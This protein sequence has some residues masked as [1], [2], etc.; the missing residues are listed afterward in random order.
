MELTAHKAWASSAS[1]LAMA[2]LGKFTGLVAVPPVESV[3]DALLQLGGALVAA[4][5]TWAA[6][7][8]AEN[9]P[10]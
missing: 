4:G 9:K 6:T 2:L 3:T 5:A 10:K 8:F 7:Y 1:V